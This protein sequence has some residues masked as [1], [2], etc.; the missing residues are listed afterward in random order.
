MIIFTE[1]INAEGK[2]TCHSKVI[3]EHDERK[4]GERKTRA[5]LENNVDVQKLHNINK[6]TPVLETLSNKVVAT[7]GFSYK[8]CEIFKNTYFEEFLLKAD[9]ECRLQ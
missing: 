9:S 2:S 8:Y 4:M 5:K 1:N 7:Q 6:K 3:G